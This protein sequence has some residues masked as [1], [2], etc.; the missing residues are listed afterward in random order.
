[1]KIKKVNLGFDVEPFS[2]P[3]GFKGGYLTGAWQTIVYAETENNFGIGLGTQSV[4]WSD[5]DV[6]SSHSEAGGNA[7]MFSVTEYAAGR[8][9]DREIE[10]PITFLESSVEDIHSYAKK[11]TGK[12]NLRKTFT[13]NALVALDNAL[14][15]L[16]A[17][18]TGRQDFLEMIPPAYR[19]P[20]KY[21]HS[22]VACIPLMSYAVPLEDIGKAIDEGFFTLKIKIGSDPDKDG[23][24]EKMLRWDTERIKSIHERFGDIPTPYTENGK[25]PYYF[26]ANG[27]YDSKERLWKLIDF[28]DG[29]GALDRV[30]IMEEPFPEELEVD[31][32]EF[33]VR[34]VADESA[35]TDED[36]IKRSQMGYKGVALKPI[37]KT[38][39]MTLKI[40]KEAE[41]LG[42]DYF[43]AD[44]T[45]I[46]P[47]VE[48]NKNL[49]CRLKPLPGL[50]IPVVE[51]NGH[52]SYRDWG[53]LIQRHPF[54]EAEW[55]VPVDGIFHLT[56]DFYAKSGGIFD[57]SEYYKSK[58]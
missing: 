51:S 30:I 50:K 49:A 25:L 54:P 28:I 7:L 47:L 16:Y 39:S 34:I 57:V 4:L 37:A 46:P 18:D 27:R 14:W 52:Q 32:G 42:M 8:L 22:L 1:M 20:L 9:K 44:L 21:K 3:L 33:P 41:R 24:R 55:V 26:D 11:I 56:P 12:E 31:V 48:W 29:L 35:H 10:D 23:D 19:G 58:V 5:A 38:L 40:V 15:V 2:T 53:K 36:V 45:V 17:K 6:F 43:C 13:L